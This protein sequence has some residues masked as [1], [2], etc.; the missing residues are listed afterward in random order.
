MANRIGLERKNQL[1]GD[2]KTAVDRMRAWKWRNSASGAHTE[3]SR[4]IA[5]VKASSS[6]ES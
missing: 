4:P 1:M 2:P 5:S 3:G 6:T